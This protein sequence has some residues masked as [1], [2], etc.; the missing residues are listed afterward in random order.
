[1]GVG[2][3]LREER[4]ALCETMETVGPDGPTLCEGW[5]VADLAAHLIVRERRLDAL[6]GVALGGPFGRHTEKVMSHM[7]DRGF[8]WM[9]DK[10]RAGPPIA[11]RLGPMA[12]VNVFENWIHHED[13]RRAA[14]SAPRPDDPEIDGILWRMSG[15]SARLAVRRLKGVG[16]AVAVEDGDDRKRVLSKTE[17]RVT[18]KG[19]VGEIVLYLSGRKEAA[20]VVLEG[21]DEAVKLVEA[22][23]F[24]L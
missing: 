12:S 10:L 5:L 20:D 9:L 22:A 18:I 24:G 23:R 4:S 3:V 14:G 1:M 16:I 11:Y 13:V 6:P 2:D 17:P 19:P 7:K 15:L 8:D 21:P